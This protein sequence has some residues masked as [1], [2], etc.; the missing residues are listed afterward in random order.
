MF[1]QGP[2]IL[3]NLT[4]FAARPESAVFFLD[5]FRDGSLGLTALV[6]AGRVA[7]AL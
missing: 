4:L 2:L 1:R 3:F 7:G 6:R 5:G